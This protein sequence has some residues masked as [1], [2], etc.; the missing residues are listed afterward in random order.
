MT[1][2]LCPH[3][4]RETNSCFLAGSHHI[5]TAGANRSTAR[6]CHLETRTLS[7]AICTAI[8]SLTKPWQDPLNIHHMTMASNKFTA[9][10]NSQPCS[11]FSPSD[12]SKQIDM[13]RAPPDTLI[14]LSVVKSKEHLVSGSFLPSPVGPSQTWAQFQGPVSALPSAWPVSL[15]PHNTSSQAPAAATI[16]NCCHSKANGGSL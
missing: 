1:A 10:T 7:V 2:C 4:P 13:S 15:A 6:G 3:S 8:S 12:H 16:F 11:I 14:N 5:Q 9:N